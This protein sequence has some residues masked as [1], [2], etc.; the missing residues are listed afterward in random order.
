MCIPSWKGL[1]ESLELLLDCVLGPVDLALETIYLVPILGPLLLYAMSVAAAIVWRALRLPLL[2]LALVGVRPHRRLAVRAVV[3]TKDGGP[4]ADCE[5]VRQRLADASSILQRQAGV[6]LVPVRL[7][8]DVRPPLPLVE[9]A[10][11]PQDERA[12][13]PSCNLTAVRDDFFVRGGSRWYRRF[14]LGDAW[15]CYFGGS[16][17]LLGRGRP[18]YL[19]VVQQVKGVEG[20]S[21]GPLADYVVVGASSSGTTMAH[22]I[23]HACGLWHVKSD[24]NLMRHILSK[25]GLTR[26]QV[27]MLTTSEHVTF[28]QSHGAKVIDMSARAGEDSPQDGCE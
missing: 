2:A 4:V 18:V 13:M 12:L 27:A 20:C 7:A 28:L 25:N 8:W 17:R 14:V 15:R 26:L 24:A 19:F 16:R 23:A 10:S 22:D 11:A 9:V 6:R 5:A 1:I 21:L 3:L